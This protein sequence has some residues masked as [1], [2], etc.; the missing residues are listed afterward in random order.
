M[1]KCPTFS[2]RDNAWS[3]CSFI[4]DSVAG[5]ANLEPVMEGAFT[6]L[7]EKPFAELTPEMKPCAKQMYYLLLNSVR[8]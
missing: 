4:F 8:R 1:N 2:G 5:M 3:L 6:G 7:A